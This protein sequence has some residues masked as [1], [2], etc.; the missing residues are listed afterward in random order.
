MGKNSLQEA[1]SNISNVIHQAVLNP[2]LDKETLIQICNGSQ[3]IGF[4]GL[5]TSLSNIP[6]ARERL[7]SKSTTKLISV[8]A[9]PFGFIPISNKLK[10]AEYAIENGA[11]ELDF[12]PNYFALE[13]GNI[14]NFAEE[15]NQLSELGTPVKVIIDGNTLLN[16]SKLS[17][18]IN[19]SIDAGATG[20]QIG[21]GFG[22]TLTKNQTQKVSKIVNNR[23]SIKAVGGIKTLDQAIEIMESGATYVGTTFGFEIAQEQKKKN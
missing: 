5:C 1:Y 15:I 13:D 23:C 7:G 2:H 14:E 16:S 19:A 18:A 3:Q 8:I 12:V 21:N 11:E 6:I 17:L 9:F 10:E 20:I 22:Q 4:A